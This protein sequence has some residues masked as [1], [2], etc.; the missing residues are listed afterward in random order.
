MRIL[1][2]R[3][4][5]RARP[6]RC[7]LLGACV[8][9]AAPEGEPVR[10]LRWA[11]AGFLT[12]DDA[13]PS[14]GRYTLRPQDAGGWAFARDGAVLRTDADLAT[15]VLTLEWQLVTDAIARRHDLF[16]LHA[17]ALAAPDGAA[18]LL[19]VGESGSGKTTLALGLMA[20]GF[21]P[22]GDDVAFLDP[23]SLALLPL[24]RAFHVRARTRQILS[25]PEMD[26]P[27]TDAEGTRWFLPPRWA[28]MP[29]PPVTAVLFPA[30]RPDTAPSL[31]PLTPAEGAQRLLRHSVTLESSPALAL[32]A[33]RAL[34]A[35]ATC[36]RLTI[37]DLAGTVARV[38]A[39]VRPA[40]DR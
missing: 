40:G 17:A 11:L 30:V 29:S 22:F 4:D 34:T 35:Q 7:G 16:H 9:V 21:R 6:L 33:V 8:E 20:E 39:L 31:V 27:W 37:G 13:G 1:D 19:I 38:R 28:T 2:P 32:S 12:A 3:A 26:A 14:V 15:A 18:T 36:Y 24:R 10:W 5:P 23:S 25:L